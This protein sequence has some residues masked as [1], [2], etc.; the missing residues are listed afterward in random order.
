MKIGYLGPRGTF[1]E[2]AASRY[3]GQTDVELVPLPTLIDVLE[4]VQ[5]KSINK[6]VVPIE[7]TIEGSINITLDALAD[8]PDLFVEGEIVLPVAQHLL[9]NQGTQLENIR[10]VWS[11]AP[12]LAQCRR[13]VRQLHASV[14]HFDSTASAALALKESGRNDVG[15]VASAWAAAQ[16][17][18]RVVVKNI[19]DS[20]ENHTRFLVVSQDNQT[21]AKAEKTMLQIIP[22]A[23]HTGVLANI[24][25]V[26][27][28]LDLN[29][30]W[31][32]SRPTKT[33]L[34]TYY[35]YLDVAAGWQDEGIQK[36]ISILEI[37][38]HQVRTLGSFRST[39]IPPF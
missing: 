20:P 33:R 10:E 2:E 24:V 32:E 28:A 25:H 35:F 22:C 37:L 7:N 29:L 23:E 1:S 38:G 14:R 18:L 19:Q 17:D 13:L 8:S 31:I 39:R 9:G 34:G 12:A 36:A 26:F 6:G 4:E 16:M 15:A 11:I 5:T 30:T 3:F 21:P 27:A